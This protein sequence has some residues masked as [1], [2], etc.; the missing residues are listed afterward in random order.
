MVDEKLFG[1][2]EASL[3]ACTDLTKLEVDALLK[4]LD[5]LT[6]QQ[7]AAKL[8]LEY[9]GIVQKYGIVASELTR[10]WYQQ[11]RDQHFEDDED[12]EA[13]EATSAQPIQRSWA[14]EDVQKASTKGLGNLTGI[15]VN[16]V[17][18]RADQTMAQNVRSDPSHPCWAIVPNFGACGF[19]VMVGS[20]GFYMKR[21]PVRVQRHDHCR[22]TVVADWD[23][24]NP[25][26][27]G[28]DPE[29]LYRAYHEAEES[30]RPYAEYTWSRMSP[31]ERKRYERK[32]YS[33]FDRFKTQL[34]SK[35]IKSRD[36][37]WVQDGKPVR[38]DYTEKA[39]SAYGVLK[40]GATDYRR[41][42]FSSAGNEWK[43]L[44][45][46][47]TLSRSGFFTH[48][49]E[50]I[51]NHGYTNID[52]DVQSRRCEFKSP[53]S[54]PNPNS[55]DELRFVQKNVQAARHQFMDD[56]TVKDGMRMV[57][58]NYYTGFSGDDEMRVFEKYCK[59]L[60]YQGFAEGLFIKKDGTVLR[61]KNRATAP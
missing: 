16:R 38:I 31:E 51:E 54:K 42:S 3:L 43:D 2:Y 55:K 35:E 29:A 10:Q 11:A 32:G 45:I 41:E 40:K 23:T 61:A 34:V 15:A 39:R 9:P 8:L 47:D 6:P 4:S 59:E 48:T 37:T 28:Y 5:G 26:L 52:A 57:M 50:T 19:C 49:H 14:E 53:E 1:K 7:R 17:M 36:P 20:N 33:A 21:Q 13:Y 44:F 58:S 46:H 18:G 25:R 27:D 30:T 56:G 24:D 22:C 12:A 60:E